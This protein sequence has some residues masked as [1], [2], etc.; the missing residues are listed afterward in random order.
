[1]VALLTRA[2]EHIKSTGGFCFDKAKDAL[3]DRHG[4]R[5]LAALAGVAVGYTLHAL[6]AYRGSKRIA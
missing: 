5:A 3:G 2:A 4:D 6:V 1:M